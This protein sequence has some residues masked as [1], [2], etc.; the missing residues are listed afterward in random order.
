LEGSDTPAH[1]EPALSHIGTI[2]KGVVDLRRARGEVGA[3]S[4]PLSPLNQGVTPPRE[5]SEASGGAR[6]RVSPH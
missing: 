2:K 1:Y 5:R 3:F 6:A 4:L